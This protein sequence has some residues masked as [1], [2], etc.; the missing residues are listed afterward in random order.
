MQLRLPRP[1]YLVI[2]TLLRMTDIYILLDSR[3]YLLTPNH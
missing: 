1:L 3:F 2:M